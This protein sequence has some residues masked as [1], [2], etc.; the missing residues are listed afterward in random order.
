MNIQWSW[1][2]NLSIILSRQGHL[3]WSKALLMSSLIAMRTSFPLL[4][5]LMQCIISKA[6]RTLSVI[7]LFGKK[8]LWD[9]LMMWGKIFLSWLASTLETILD[10]TLLR[11]MG[12][13]SVIFWGLF[14]FGIRHIWVAL[15]S[16]GMVPKFKILRTQSVTL[17]PTIFQSFW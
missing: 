1:K 12:R 15:M 2:P 3:A 10:S 11:L 4:Y 13:K 16:R 7:N 9:M 5:W 17:G 8:A 6:T 14:L